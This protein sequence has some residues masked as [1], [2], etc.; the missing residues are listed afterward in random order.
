M[1]SSTASSRTSARRAR[2]RWPRKAATETARRPGISIPGRLAEYRKDSD[3]EAGSAAARGD[4]VRV[5]DLEGLADEVVDEVDLG[6]VHV[7]ERHLVDQHARLALLEDEVIG[8][9]IADEVELVGEAGA[10]AAFD[11]NAQRRLVVL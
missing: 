6:A 4:G 5:P 10:T 11:R 9:R 3:R 2:R 1:R 8:L 7:D